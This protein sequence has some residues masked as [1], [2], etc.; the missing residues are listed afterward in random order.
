MSQVNFLYGTLFVNDEVMFAA[1]FYINLDL[2]YFLSIIRSVVN[3]N[4]A[5]KSLDKK[6]T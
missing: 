4:D 6:N 1:L 3:E 5:R 2:L